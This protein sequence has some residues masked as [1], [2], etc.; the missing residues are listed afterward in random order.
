MQYSMPNPFLLLVKTL[1]LILTLI[2]V[3]TALGSSPILSLGSLGNTVL[4]SFIRYTSLAFLA[5]VELVSIAFVSV[6]P[7]PSSGCLKSH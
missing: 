7:A 1:N 5:D 4:S 6:H 2:S 3:S